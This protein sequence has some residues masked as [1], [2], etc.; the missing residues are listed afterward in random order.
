MDNSKYVTLCDLFCLRQLTP[1]VVFKNFIHIYS[2]QNAAITKSYVVTFSQQRLGPSTFAARAP[3]GWNLEILKNLA[4]FS[5]EK[6]LLKWLQI[7]IITQI[8]LA[9]W[10]VLAYDLIEDRW[11]IDV[12]HRAECY[13]FSRHVLAMPSL[14]TRGII[15]CIC[16]SS[17]LS[18]DWTTDL[19]LGILESLCTFQ[20]LPSKSQG[21][22]ELTIAL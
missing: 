20:L 19:A 8:I 22:I 18:C 9:L 2:L 10:L 13:C 5:S 12:I 16:R 14:S 21:A 4:I 11:T 6:Y 17:R 7:Y 1:K 3:F 15:I